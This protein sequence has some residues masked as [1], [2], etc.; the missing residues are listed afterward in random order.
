MTSDDLKQIRGVVR[1]EVTFALVPIRK[2]LDR[3]SAI[4][5]G[6]TKTLAS[7]TEI[8]DSHTKTLDSH[9]KM[10]VSHT[11]ILISHTKTLDNHTRTL[12]SHTKKLDAIWDQVVELSED[13]TEVKV[14]LKS[15]A[16]DLDY[17]KK[18][19]TAVEDPLG[20]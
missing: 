8:L 10:L 14:T 4:L 2:T 3:H 6:H 15:H 13:M 17:T 1:E 19:V 11:E 16:V 18:R 20:I 7:H 12:A 9:T 5:D